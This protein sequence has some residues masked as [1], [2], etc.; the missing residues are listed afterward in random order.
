[1]ERFTL[2]TPSRQYIH[3]FSQINGLNQSADG[4]INPFDVCAGFRL[5]RILRT[6]IV[7]TIIT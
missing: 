2:I 3:A 7:T 1:M 5:S 4:I 6:I